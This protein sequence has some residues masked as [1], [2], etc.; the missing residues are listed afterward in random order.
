[1]KAPTLDSSSID[2]L[3]SRRDLLKIAELEDNIINIGDSPLLCLIGVDS[4]NLVSATTTFIEKK[5]PIPVEKYEIK[6]ENNAAKI[7]KNSERLK[8]D[9]FHIISFFDYPP[10]FASQIAS[11]L[12]FY[13]DYI[14]EFKL[15]IIIILTHDFL[16]TLIQKAYDFYSIAAFTAFLTDQAQEIEKDLGEYE[17]KSSNVKE[18]ESALADL[19]QYRKQPNASDD[20]LLIKLLKTASLAFPLFKLD[21]AIKLLNEAFEIAKKNRNRQ[22]QAGIFLS[23]SLLYQLKDD[24]ITARNYD[25]R[26]LKIAR[27]INDFNIECHALGYMGTLY[28]QIYQFDKALKMHNNAIEISQKIGDLQIE[29]WNLQNIGHIFQLKGKFDIALDYVKRALEIRKK[30]NDTGNMVS[31]LLAFGSIYYDK[32]GYDH[33]IGFLKMALRLLKIK[34]NLLEKATII[35]HIG[36]ILCARGDLDHGLKYY[37]RALKIIQKI[38]ELK[39]LY[40]EVISDIVHIYEV[41]GEPGKARKYLQKLP[42]NFR[43]AFMSTIGDLRIHKGNI[44]VSLEKYENDLKEAKKHKKLKEQAIILSKIGEIFTLKGNH[45]AALN[46][47]RRS[48]RLIN[49]NYLLIEAFIKTNIGKIYQ[50]QGKLDISLNYFQDALKISKKQDY[51][52]IEA[53]ALHNVGNVHLKKSS[54]EDA[55]KYYREA[56]KIAQIAGF[57]K[58]AASAQDSINAATPQ[59]KTIK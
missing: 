55:L 9:T 36:K 28:S 16:E 14:P 12:I 47:Q 37:T 27:L 13:R 31:N 17:G 41:K 11:N 43:S 45:K 53:S 32:G 40:F 58:L 52:E 59:Q 22:Y 21:G 50:Y 42:H 6:T 34:G 38:D 26:A 4:H 7:L 56:L 8:R 1:M 25:K 24:F 15:K 29:A 30:F 46:Y 10:A 19:D 33:A 39:N 20:I 3:L 57:K 49:N 2:P 44:D 48:L 51:L 18:F 23:M 5:S 54:P 35:H